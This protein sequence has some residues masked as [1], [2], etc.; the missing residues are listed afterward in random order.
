[1]AV[2]RGGNRSIGGFLSVKLTLKWSDLLFGIITEIQMKLYKE[3]VMWLS[4]DF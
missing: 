1:M 2:Y 3:F 4:Q